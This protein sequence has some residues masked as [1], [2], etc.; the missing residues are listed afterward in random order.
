MARGKAV[1]ASDV[2]GHRELIQHGVTGLLFRAD[3]VASL[4][5]E[6]IRAATDRNL[7]DKL[8]KLGR[9][10]V[11]KERKWSEIVSKYLTIYDQLLH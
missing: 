2:G 5:E 4:T 1:V 8:G 10:H 7:R 6:G 3:D 11:E 9:K